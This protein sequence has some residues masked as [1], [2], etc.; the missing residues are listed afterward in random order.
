MEKPAEATEP[1]AEHHCQALLNRTSR[2]RQFLGANRRRVRATLK[3]GNN[4]PRW[5][6]NVTSNAIHRSHRR[7]KV[8]ATAK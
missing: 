7:E 4:R 2:L 3:I 6:T 8:A 5:D 1:P